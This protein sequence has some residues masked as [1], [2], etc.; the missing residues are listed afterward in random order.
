[1]Q[2]FANGTCM[3]S[4]PWVDSVSCAE[5][6]QNL[7]LSWSDCTASTAGYTKL[8]FYSD[9]ADSFSNWDAVYHDE[10]LTCEDRVA[11]AA[12]V[13]NLEPG[14]I[15]QSEITVSKSGVPHIWYVVI[16]NC[17][18]SLN[19]NT[20]NIEAGVNISLYNKGW[21]LN[22][23]LQISC[24]GSCQ[25]GVDEQGLWAIT[26]SF[27]ILYTLEGLLFVCIARHFMQK[28]LMHELHWFLFFA[29]FA[30]WLASD[31]EF[32]YYDGYQKSGVGNDTL[33]IFA[34]SLEMMGFIIFINVLIVIARGWPITTT[35]LSR[36]SENV[37]LTMIIILVY[38]ALYFA[39]MLRAPGDNSYLYSNWAGYMFIAM[40]LVLLILFLNLIRRTYIFEK[41]LVKRLFYRRFAFIFSLWFI[42]LPIFVGIASSLSVWNQAK[43]MYAIQRGIQLLAFCLIP[44]IQNPSNAYEVRHSP[45]EL[46]I[47]TITLFLSLSYPSFS[48][49]P[50]LYACP[51]IVSVRLSRSTLS[52]TTTML[53]SPPLPDSCGCSPWVP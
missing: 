44:L 33:S 25:F 4:S 52:S 50:P 42:Q 27:L 10:T 3:V 51:T 48:P 18:G 6:N 16:A 41:R 37:F 30:Y 19:P 47:L 11:R 34:R 23:D 22:S 29:F 36:K 8:L 26:L 1:M 21:T 46:L 7:Q 31:L 45:S 53:A 15:S 49:P 5:Y 20:P 43:V 12:F 9:V 32:A 24:R 2:N 38:V 14:M 13:V 39:D 17:Q 28:R 35:K 40:N